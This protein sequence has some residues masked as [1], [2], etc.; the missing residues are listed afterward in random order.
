[1][2]RI[3]LLAAAFALAACSA[4]SPWAGG[5]AKS[6]VATPETEAADVAVVG[7]APAAP[8]AAGESGE[9]VAATPAAPAKYSWQVKKEG[10]ET[11]EAKQPA[12]GAPADE[13]RARIL[14]LRLESGMLAFTRK[15]K[16]DDGAFLQLTKGDKA[17]LIRVLRSDDT[18]T[19]ADIPAGQ[20]PA[21]TPT[22][23]VGDEVGCGTPSDLPPQ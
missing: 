13:T 2:H 3:A 21:K 14:A 18:M 7:T 23:E 22:L 10:E 8:A 17:L 12:T 11:A 16:P 1:M 5:S 19:V 6:P 4:R 20:D 15:E 9:A